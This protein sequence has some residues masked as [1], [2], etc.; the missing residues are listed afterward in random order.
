M[1]DNNYIAT[2]NDLLQNQTTAHQQEETDQAGLQPVQW[3]PVDLI[4]RLHLRRHTTKKVDSMFLK[5][6]A[7]I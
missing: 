4:L 1:S 2:M 7:W 3:V 5:R 6:H